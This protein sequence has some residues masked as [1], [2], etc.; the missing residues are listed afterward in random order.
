[1]ESSVIEIKQYHFSKSKSEEPTGS[2]VNFQV[3]N[4]LTD[5]SYSDTSPLLGLNFL[6]CKMKEEIV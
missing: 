5:D 1:M 6:V 4:V 3:V 2:L